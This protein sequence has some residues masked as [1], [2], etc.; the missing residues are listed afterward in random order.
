ME[1]VQRLENQS[2]HADQAPPGGGP[3]VLRIMLGNRLRGLREASGLTRKTAGNT[4]RASDAKMSR[5]ELGRV[6]YKQRDVA[7]LITLYGVEDPKEREAYLSLAHQAN[8]PGWWHKYG[9][10]LPSWF[11]TYVGLE[12]AASVIRSYQV[13]FV[14]GLFQTDEYARA[15]ILL[16]YPGVS[17]S[18]IDMRAN[19]RMARQKILTALDGPKIWAVLDEAALRRPVGGIEVM[20]TQVQQLID[21]A[22]LPNVTVQVVSFAAGGHAAAG[23]PFSILRFSASDISDIA[24]LEQL[25]GAVYLEKPADV[26]NYLMVMDRLCAEATSPSETTNLLEGL[27]KEL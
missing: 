7:D 8:A 15:V 11:E 19:L 9:E 12:Q 4:I 27:L 21:L 18:E 5:L 1:L 13:Q 26:G 2:G 6:G 23:G 3:T 16:G 24:Y 14:P 25:T 17:E 20:R 22:E 10:V